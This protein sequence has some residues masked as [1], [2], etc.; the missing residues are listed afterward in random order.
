[1]DFSLPDSSKLLTRIQH[2]EV[3]AQAAV[4]DLLILAAAGPAGFAISAVD[5][6]G[7]LARSTSA[8]LK[9]NP[10]VWHV[11]WRKKSDVDNV[12]AKL[13]LN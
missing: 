4:R 2:R 11:V 7:F 3:Q 13:D 5:G 12:A 9:R 1:L 10:A 6:E 8:W